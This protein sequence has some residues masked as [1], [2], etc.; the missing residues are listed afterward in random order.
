MSLAYVV[1]LALMSGMHAATWGAYKDSPFEG[2]KASSFVRTLAV[3]VVTA[4]ALVTATDLEKTI[5]PVVLVGLIYGVERL[6]TELWKSYL[7]EDDQSAYAIPMRVAILGRTVDGRFPRYL[8]GS[9]VVASIVVLCGVAAALQPADGG[10]VVMLVLMGGTGGWLTAVGGAWKDA[11]V[12]GFSGWKFL[13]SPVV[14]TVWTIMLL[15]FTDEWVTLSVAA[16]GLAVLSIETYKTF[17]TGGRPPGKFDGKPVLPPRGAERDRCRLLHSGT[18]AG[19]ACVTGVAALF[20]GGGR[21]V[22]SMVSLVVLTLVAATMAAVLATRPLEYVAPAAVVRRRV[23]TGAVPPE[24]PGRTWD[25]DASLRGAHRRAGL[26]RR[27]PVDS[28]LRDADDRRDRRT[29]GNRQERV[30]LDLP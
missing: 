6:A 10:P 20:E 22:P 9:V 7:R 28:R 23:V 14:A 5:G 2:F 17:F 12:E 13:R 16:A 1:L 4:V 8:A 29:A 24:R 21:L 15:P 30:G 27:T 11:P 26:A 18:Y 19:L 25:A 3:A